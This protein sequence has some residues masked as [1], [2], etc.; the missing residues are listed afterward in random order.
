MEEDIVDKVRVTAFYSFIKC[1]FVF[2]HGKQEGYL[3]S[4]SWLVVQ[5]LGCQPGA[6]LIVGCSRDRLEGY[7]T[8][9]IKTFDD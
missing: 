7:T 2:F 4:C 5:E 1:N 8:L 3:F 9:T 6:A